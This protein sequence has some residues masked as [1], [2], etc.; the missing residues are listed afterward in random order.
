MMKMNKIATIVAL[1]LALAVGTG[2]MSAQSGYDVFQ[3]ALVQERADGNLDEALKLYQRVVNE[4]SRDRALAAKALV[5]MAECYQKLG[6]AESRKVYE[7]VVREFADQTE[8]ATTARTRLSALT[9]PGGTAAASGVVVKSM[10]TG[11]DVDTE[12]SP[13]PDGRYLPFV[14][15]SNDTVHVRDLATGLNRQLTI[16]GHPFHNQDEYAEGTIDPGDFLYREH[17][18]G[19]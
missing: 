4:F 1:A 9:R 13:S 19:E 14:D 16:S 11:P 12:G 2:R 18:H 8:S 5:R 6:D 17:R 15:W 3:K 7:R 10:W